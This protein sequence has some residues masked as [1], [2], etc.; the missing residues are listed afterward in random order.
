MNLLYIVIIAIIL[1]EKQNNF[2]AILMQLPF[3][4]FHENFDI[5]G[6]VFL[7]KK[8]WSFHLK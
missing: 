3:R 1:A 5:N 2:F 8:V 6:N 4:A 7:H